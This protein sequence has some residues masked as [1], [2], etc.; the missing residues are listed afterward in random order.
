MA[1]LLFRGQH[2]LGQKPGKVIGKRKL[3]TNSPCEHRLK[4]PDKILTNQIQHYI[5][6]QYMTTEQ[7]LFQG[8]KAV[9]IFENW[10]MH[11]SLTLHFCQPWR[12]Q[13]YRLVIK[14]VTYISE[15]KI[16]WILG[17]NMTPPVGSEA[18]SPNQ[19][20]SLVVLQQNRKNTLTTQGESRLQRAQVSSG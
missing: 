16:S 10:L 19:T 20:H 15:C 17:N 5:K 18:A 8:C 4:C 6:R 13:I 3:Q 1:Q 7:E 2:H 12:L 11:A 9:L 14:I